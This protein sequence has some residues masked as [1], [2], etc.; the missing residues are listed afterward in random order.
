MQYDVVWNQ[1]PRYFFVTSGVGFS[2]VSS[3]N[4]FD[5]ALIKAGIGQ[6]NLVP[7]SSIIPG[8]AVEVDYVEITPG[9]I[10]FTVMSRIDGRDG[11]EISA[12]LAWGFG[13]RSDGVRYGL[14]VEAYGKVSGNEV[15]SMLRDRIEATAKARNMKL[16]YV[17]YRVEH[18]EKV[19]K[20]MYA[21]AIV[22]L[23]F[24][25]V[26][27]YSKVSVREPLSS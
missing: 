6:C 25:P 9:S 24:V 27:D 12:G 7:V 4:A 10:V 21:S 1:L 16:E 22:A 15:K 14:V 11:E 17:K 18:V 5:E 13:V 3:L 2:S 26:V 23:V 20:G 8:N 19:P